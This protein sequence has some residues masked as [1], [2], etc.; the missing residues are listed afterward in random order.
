MKVRGVKGGQTA[1]KKKVQGTPLPSISFDEIMA[2]TEEKQ[3]KSHLDEMMD[4]ISKKGKEL[5][6][7]RDIE[8][9]VVYKEMVRAFIDEA[10]NHGLK[11]VERRGF[12]RAG[13][14][15][16]MRL[17]SNIDEKLINL[18]DEMILNE[19]SSIKL[20]SKIGEIQGLLLNL[21][22]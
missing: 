8:I 5:A 11:I 19:Q 6:E 21:Y 9:L 16:V 10:V 18:T 2:I 3:E 4:E 12:G 22:A 13:R 7:K 14:S 15:K 1:S 20:L 17:V